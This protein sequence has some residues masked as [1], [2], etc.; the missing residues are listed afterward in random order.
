MTF[1]DSAASPPASALA[2]APAV[3]AVATTVPLSLS[4]VVVSAASCGTLP[5]PPSPS[6]SAAGA[7]ASLASADEAALASSPPSAAVAAVAAVPAPSA[8]L[9]LA[10]FA[11]AELAALPSPSPADVDEA[12]AASVGCGSSPIRW[13]TLSWCAAEPRRTSDVPLCAAAI[14]FRSLLSQIEACFAPTMNGSPLGPLVVTDSQLIASVSS[15]LMTK[16]MMDRFNSSSSVS[17]ADAGESGALIAKRLV[18]ELELELPTKAT[19][20]SAVTSPSAHDEDC[21]NT[22]DPTALLTA[23]AHIGRSDVSGQLTS[24]G[25]G[26]NGNLERGLCCL[27]SHSTSASPSS[28]VCVV[29]LKPSAASSLRA[30]ARHMDTGLSAPMASSSVCS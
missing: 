2:S 13:E 27:I 29:S 24:G 10:E 22:S 1:G 26:R 11:L 23:H 7:A 3:G 15:A 9:L 28:P 14:V 19:T 20:F 21:S 30:G 12:D 5:P 16:P 18:F 17:A 25:P 8:P 6:P 4:P